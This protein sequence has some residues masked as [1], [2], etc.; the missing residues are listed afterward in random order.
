M[1]AEY[2]L[3]E[4]DGIRVF[5]IEIDGV[6]HFGMVKGWV[7][8]QSQPIGVANISMMIEQLTRIKNLMQGKES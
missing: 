4:K 7:N 5:V 1:S 6:Y 2:P 8:W 3:Y